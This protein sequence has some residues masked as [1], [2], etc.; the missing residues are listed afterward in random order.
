MDQ[1][2]APLDPHS[3]CFLWLL[4][5]GFVCFPTSYK[6]YRQRLRGS[7]KGEGEL[8]LQGKGTTETMWRP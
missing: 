8:H 5:G 2:T 1:E 4:I 3:V 7:A 6:D